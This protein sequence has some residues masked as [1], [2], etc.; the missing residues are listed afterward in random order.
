VGLIDRQSSCQ[1]VAVVVTVVLVSE[2]VF[3]RRFF[4]GNAGDPYNQA[5]T[6]AK[7]EVAA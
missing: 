1:A 2:L 7:Q 5:A 6:L 3:Q 4:D